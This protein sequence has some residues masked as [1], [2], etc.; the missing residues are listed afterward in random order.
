MKQNKKLKSD[1]MSFQIQYFYKFCNKTQ[2]MISMFIDLL[3]QWLSEN[4]FY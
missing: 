2:G 3:F 1:S 4:I